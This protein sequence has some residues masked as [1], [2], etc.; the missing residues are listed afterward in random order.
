MHALHNI[1]SALIPNGLLVDTQPIA[2][3]L[4][5]TANGAALGTVDMRAWIETIQAV[6]E[7]IDETIATGLYEPVAERNLVVASMFD[8]GPE[9]LAITGAWRGARVPKRLAD[10]LA[11]LPDPVAVEQ[12]V[13]VRVLRR[14]QAS[15]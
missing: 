2:S 11:D 9:C 8:D 14:G 13:R 15:A 6:D 10:R 5:V 4:R 1:H 3:H 12:Q 7:R